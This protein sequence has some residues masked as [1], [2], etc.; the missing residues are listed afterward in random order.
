MAHSMTTREPQ[1]RATRWML[2]LARRNYFV[3]KELAAL[4]SVGSLSSDRLLLLTDETWELHRNRC[5][6]ARNFVEVASENPAY[7]RM[8]ARGLLRRLTIWPESYLPG[9]FRRAV[10]SRPSTRRRR[11]RVAS[12]TS[13]AAR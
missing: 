6:A 12:R 10:E 9:P 4:L 13:P 3:R 11:A 8:V 5:G 1:S 7:P 2:A